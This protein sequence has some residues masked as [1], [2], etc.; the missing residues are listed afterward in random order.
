[1][2]RAQ[3]LARTVPLYY[4]Y[5]DAAY[6]NLLGLSAD[7]RPP[8]RLTWMRHDSM[9][10]LDVRGEGEGRRRQDTE[11]RCVGTGRAPSTRWVTFAHLRPRRSPTRSQTRRQ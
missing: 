1:M 3:A 8:A 4:T 6:G 5:P 11:E 10:A 7:V 9:G 2:Q